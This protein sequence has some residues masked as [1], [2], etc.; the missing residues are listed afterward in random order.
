MPHSH[1]KTFYA[2]TMPGLER[3]AWG[4]IRTRF[5]E[6]VLQGFKQL[7]S[8]NGL[9]LFDFSGDARELFGLRTV[10]D[11]F[12]LAERIPKVPWGYEG[13]SQIYETVLQS[14]KFEQMLRF[15]AQV[16]GLRLGRR[17]AFRLIVRMGGIKQPY[18]RIDLQ[19]SLEKALQK[20]SRRRWMPVDEGEDVEIWANLIGLDFICGIRL[21]DERMRHRD[22]QRIHLP[23]SL[24]PSVAAAMA[25][26]T[27]P[28]PEDVF[29]DPMCGT[30]TILIE[31]ALLQRHALLLGGDIEEGALFAAGENIGRKHKPRQLFHWDARHLPFRDESIDKV[32]SNLPFGVQMSSPKENVRLYYP[33]FAELARVL[34]PKGKAAILSKDSVLVKESAARALLD[35]RKTYSVSI[36]GQ[37]AQLFLIERRS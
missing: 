34:K 28:Q 26:L 36:L 30:G 22:Y 1:K 29:L 3:I 35:V 27:D 11:I 37:K 5:P 18:R 17:L 12:V 8:K 25:W 10:E 21:S 7:K 33:F 20:H 31:R 15:A 16:R 14:P 2:H 4:E 32:A 6:T 24:R 13:L 23:A 9:V 19:R